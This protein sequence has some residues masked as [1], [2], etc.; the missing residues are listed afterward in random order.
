MGMTLPTEDKSSSRT[1]GT[2][3]DMV[4]T[5][6]TTVEPKQE[7]VWSEQEIAAMS[8]AEFDKFETEI[9]DAMQEG[10]IIK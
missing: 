5:K 8:V 10:R 6:T 1:K 4:S 2:A 7:R 3:A 9:S